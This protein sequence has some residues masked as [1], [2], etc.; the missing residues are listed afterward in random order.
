[1]EAMREELKQQPDGQLSQTDP[2]S[3][4]MISQAKGTG[5]VGYNVQA[6]VDAQ[7]HLIVVH[8]VTNVG[9]DRAQ[10]TKMAIAVR[11]AMD[12]RRLQAL[13]ARGYFSGPEI[14]ACAEAGI[15]PLVPKPMTSGAK[16][17]GRFS[18]ADF[19]YIAKDNEYQCPAGQR[20]I[21]RMTTLEHGLKL[22][23]YGSSACP[24]CPLKPRC[25]P[26]DYRR[27]TRWER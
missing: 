17:E 26:S 16:A 5:L 10:L 24:R 7:H 13:A 14:K 22:H 9:S 25:T 18:K 21:Y 12:K 20:A 8:E 1:M 11:E 19:I 2:D 15:V 4:S 6:A 27:F 3:R 23:R